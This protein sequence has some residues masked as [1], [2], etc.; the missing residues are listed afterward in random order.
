MIQLRGI[1]VS[2]G[3][4]IGKAHIVKEKRV[5]IKKRKIKNTDIEHEILKFE[6]VIDEILRETDKFIEFYTTNKDDKEIFESHQLILKDPE[7][8]NSILAM[9][10]EELVCLE[11][12]IHKHFHNVAS[13]FESLD[14]D[15]FA[16]KATDYLDVSN[17]IINFL[18]GKRGF[19]QNHFDA[20]EI[21]ILYTTTPSQVAYLAKAG[22]KGFYTAKGSE[23]SHNSII[24]R[25]FGLNCVVGI[26]DLF[27]T[28]KNGDYLILDGSDGT[29]IINPDLEVLK[30]YKLKLAKQ[31]LHKAELL[32]IINI[33]VPKIVGKKIALKMNIELPEEIEFITKMKPDGIGL[34]RTEFLY[35]DRDSLPTEEEQFEVYKNLAKKL[36][37]KG[38][39]IRTF[40]LGGDKFSNIFTT[41]KEENPFL[42]NRG[43]RFSISHPNIFRTQI[44]AILRASIYGNIK[45]M[46]P[47]V[48]GLDDF[49][50]AQRF[51]K[52]AISNLQNRGYDVN[53]DIE[54][55]VMIEIPSA[56]LCSEM[57]AE[58][59]DFFSIGTN[60]LI[61]YTLSV[62][63]TNDLLNNY[64]VPH[65][66]AVLQLIK[67]T[68]EGAKKHN[69]PVSVCGQ[70]A[71]TPKYIALLLALGV[72]E[73]SIAPSAFLDVKKE[74][75]NL[76]DETIMKLREFNIKTTVNNIEKKLREVSS[77]FE[78]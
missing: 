30:E 19:K 63:R 78:V 10:K 61:Q 55:G 17:R 9:I 36:D 20:D 3:L 37:G 53:S 26:P 21:P 22:V 7:L 25:S 57:L 41:A 71:S 76:N 32:G 29:V 23:T 67:Y 54:I 70:M 66:P 52:K 24:A 11:H 59:A 34:F 16:Q 38:L 18:L 35:M 69:I 50:K 58:H 15:F 4:A 49:I 13:Y 31:E 14:N 74:I 5:E 73:L 27:D 64:Y 42:G 8:K 47:M 43:L 68:V 48:I 56:A 12:A 72:D 45:I 28:I 77:E 1:G 40:D 39:V 2:P 60:D 65:N 33:E 62:D 6:K 46:F 51:V 44:N 75:I